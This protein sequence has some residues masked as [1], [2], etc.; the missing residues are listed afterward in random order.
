MNEDYFL[1][2]AV[3]STSDVQTRCSLVEK[4]LYFTARAAKQAI[5]QSYSRLEFCEANPEL[6][7]R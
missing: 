6:S 7:A 5:T 3:V 2:L 1:E 4:A